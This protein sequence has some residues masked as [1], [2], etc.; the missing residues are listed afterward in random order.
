MI[1]SKEMKQQTKVLESY[2]KK[3][4]ILLKKCQTEGSVRI[5]LKEKRTEYYQVTE[6]GDTKG[7]YIPKSEIEK[8][9]ALAQKGYL[10]KA[11]K[12]LKKHHRALQLVDSECFLDKLR[13]LYESMHPKR[14][15]LITPIILSDS[16]FIRRWEM[17]EYEPKK[18]F[19]SDTSSHYTDKGERVRSKSEVLIANRFHSLKIPYVYEPGLELGGQL[20]YPD[21]K[22]LNVR[23]RKSFFFENF[24]MMDNPEYSAHALERIN[25]YTLNGYVSGDGLL[26]TLESS[27]HPLDMRALNKIIEKY[28]I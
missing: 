26:Y 27:V 4:E 18:F 21:F 3:A 25:N 13:S 7:I 14:R 10:E 15:E 2:I 22:V 19:D 23:T 12:I 24:G 9:R 28:L 6:P 17:R 5:C 16:E 1:T 8:A 11:L 20:I